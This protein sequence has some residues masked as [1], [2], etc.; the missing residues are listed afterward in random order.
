[1]GENVHRGH[2]RVSLHSRCG[3]A[4]NRA[5]EE[6]RFTQL[7]VGGLGILAVT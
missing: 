3:R 6:A 2:A 7:D 1:M 4:N 5:S